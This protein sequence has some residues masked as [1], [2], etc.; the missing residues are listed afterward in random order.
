MAGPLYCMW[1]SDR[2]SNHPTVTQLGARC[3]AATD[4]YAA[5]QTLLINILDMQVSP[6]IV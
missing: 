1:E 5:W 3:R 6:V 2:Y 4:D